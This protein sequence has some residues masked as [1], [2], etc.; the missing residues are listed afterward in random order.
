MHKL[1]N[2]IWQSIL[3]VFRFDFWPDTQGVKEG[4]LNPV[5]A[6]AEFFEQLFMGVILVCSGIAQFVFVLVLIVVCAA[7]VIT[8]PWILLLLLLVL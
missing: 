5:S 3:C 7:L 2:D 1:L 6:R 8:C 4:H